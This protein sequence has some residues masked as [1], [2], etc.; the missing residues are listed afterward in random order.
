MATSPRC[1]DHCALQATRASS[2]TALLCS[3]ARQRERDMWQ[4]SRRVGSA[5]PQAGLLPQTRGSVEPV[6]LPASVCSIKS[7]LEP[8][9]RRRSK[10]AMAH[11][12]RPARGAQPRR[13]DCR[14]SVAADS[15]QASLTPS[16]TLRRSRRSPSRTT[17]ESTRCSSSSRLPVSL[18]HCIVLPCSRAMPW[19]LLTPAS[20]RDLCLPHRALRV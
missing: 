19:S 15:F 4:R 16:S 9:T 17:A 8:H 2:D 7:T 5:G 20:P 14:F 11:C 10:A 6:R 13:R 3:A 12:L 18:C 1:A